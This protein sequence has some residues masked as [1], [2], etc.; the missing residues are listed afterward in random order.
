MATIR[1]AQVCY[2]SSGYTCDY[3]VTYSAYTSSYLLAYLLDSRLLA[4][5]LTRM[6]FVFFDMFHFLLK[7]IRVQKNQ[8]FIKILY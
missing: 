4:Y 6:H 3:F 1:L 5:L 8:L 2:P 7:Q